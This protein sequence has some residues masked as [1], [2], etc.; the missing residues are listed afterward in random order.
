MRADPENPQNGTR[1]QTYSVP[2]RELGLALRTV[3]HAISKDPAR[4]YGIEIKRSPDGATITATD[5][6]RLFTLATALDLPAGTVPLAGVKTLET[7]CKAKGMLSIVQHA[8]GLIECGGVKLAR[9][10]HEFPPWEKLIPTPDATLYGESK[11]WIGTLRATVPGNGLLDYAVITID[12]EASRAHIVPGREPV[13]IEAWIPI[14][15]D[16]LAD[17]RWFGT[18]K[19]R[20][21]GDRSFQ[22][23]VSSRYLAEAIKAVGSETF[24]LGFCGELE[25]ILVR[26]PEGTSGLV[27]PCRLK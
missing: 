25:P 16:T 21:D 20:D 13:E 23:G 22:F 4:N 24:S 10:D 9:P 11:E 5:G 17:S 18:R 14:E 6:H 15:C 1:M 19:A 27:M 7:A 2:S 3:K 8:G 12:V 26:G